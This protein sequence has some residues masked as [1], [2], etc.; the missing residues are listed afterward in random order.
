VVTTAVLHLL[1]EEPHYPK[2]GAYPKYGA[3]ALLTELSYATKMYV[4]V[5]VQ[6]HALTSEY[7]YIDLTHSLMELSPS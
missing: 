2:L 6:L 4:E 7:I 3:S 1:P 5:E